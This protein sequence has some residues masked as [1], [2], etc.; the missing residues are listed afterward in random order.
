MLERNPQDLML[1]MIYSNY[2]WNALNDRPLALR[3]Q[4]EAVALAPNDPGQ[5]LTL[6]GYLIASGDKASRAEAVSLVTAMEHADRDG[7]LAEPLA[8]LRVLLVRTATSQVGDATSS[9]H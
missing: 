3:V 2:A 8:K 6:A 1:H 5:R 7:R 4:R 9:S